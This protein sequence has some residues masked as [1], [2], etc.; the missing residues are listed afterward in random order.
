LDAVVANA[1]IGDHSPLGTITEEQFD[2]TF[3]TNVKG[4]LF[5]IQPAVP[6]MKAG[7]SIIIIRSIGSVNPPRGMSIYGGSKAAVRNFIRS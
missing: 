6:L 1:G 5:T 4:V 3:N 7:G 2:Q